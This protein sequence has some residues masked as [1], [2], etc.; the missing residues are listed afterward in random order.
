MSKI[1]EARL[2]ANI[3]QAEMSKRLEI[4]K[5]TIEAWETGDRN[6]PA[7]VERLVVAELERIAKED[8]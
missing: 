2:K 8:I 1:K 6:P 4:P 3:S 5:R 7:Y